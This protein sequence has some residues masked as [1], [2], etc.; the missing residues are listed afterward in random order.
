MEGLEKTGVMNE[1][2][3]LALILDN[4]ITFLILRATNN[5]SPPEHLACLVEN[6]GN[7]IQNIP[8]RFQRTPQH[9]DGFVLLH[10]CPAHCHT[11]AV[12]LPGLLL[13]KLS[14]S[15]VP[16]SMPSKRLCAKALSRS[17]SAFCFSSV[18]AFVFSRIG[19][20]FPYTFVLGFHLEITP[21]ECLSCVRAIAS[22]IFHQSWPG[23]PEL[24]LLYIVG[25]SSETEDN[26]LFCSQF[27]ESLTATVHT[28][29]EFLTR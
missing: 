14:D 3:N 7:D 21:D 24:C 18:N 13:L 15:L 6:I 4:K 16:L 8:T 29:S 25:K 20:V 17:V 11:D 12:L 10:R 28:Q 27:R 9:P 2:S 23:L 5:G 22:L 1:K 19:K 26:L